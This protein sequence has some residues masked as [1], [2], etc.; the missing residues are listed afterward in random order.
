MRYGAVGDDDGMTILGLLRATDAVYMAA[1]AAE[2]YSDSRSGHPAFNHV[3][4]L[5]IEQLGSRA[6]LWA[7]YGNGERGDELARWLRATADSLPKKWPQTIQ[8]IGQKW[9][10]VSTRSEWQANGPV[11]ALV[12]GWLDDEQRS[13]F[14]PAGSGGSPVPLTMM[15]AP[16]PYF[17][18]WG[19]VAATVAFA[20]A[21]AVDVDADDVRL[22]EVAMETTIQT[23]DDLSIANRDAKEP[24]N[25]IRMNQDGSFQ[26]VRGWI[27]GHGNV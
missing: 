27:G 25:L 3:P 6:A 4:K 2:A 22:F 17:A 24:L 16:N 19:N 5:K 13:Y 15:G 1:D 21:K 11:G 18:G 9:Q 12:A 7:Y 20:A 8:E 14:L 10:E 26:E 23:I